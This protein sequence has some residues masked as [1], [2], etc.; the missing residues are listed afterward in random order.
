MATAG[1]KQGGGS[2]KPPAAGQE[3]DPRYEWEENASS[4]ILRIHLSGFRKQDFRVQV[5]GAGRLTVRGQRS[6]AA[7]NARHSRFNKVFQLPS[8]SNLDDIA[9]RFDLGVLTLTV[10]KRLPAPAKE[11][12]QQAKKPEDAAAAAATKQVAGAK[13]AKS[14]PE[15]QHKEEAAAKEDK[16]KTTAAAPAPAADTTAKEDKPK[17]AAAAPAPAADTK[18]QPETQAN[19]ESKATDPTESLAERRT[20]EE[21]ANANAAAAAEHQRK[22]CRG[23]KERVA[24]ELQGLAGSEW[25]EGLVETIKRN[26]EVVAVAVAAFSLGVFVSSRLFSRSSRN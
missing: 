21:R 13:G 19:A 15:Q 4:F 20:E 22:A 24:E 7:A 1:S 16:P 5:D 3:L 2:S 17:A 8:T 9:G 25:A 23:F 10:P 6:D 11:D 14:E 18:K 26:R 12:Q